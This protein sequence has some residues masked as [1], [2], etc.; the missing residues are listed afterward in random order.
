MK[1]ICIVL[2]LFCT[3]FNLLAYDDDDKLKLAV[4]EFED[5]SGKISKQTLSEATEY[6]RN[7][8][9]SSNTYIVIAKERQE[10]EMIKAMKKESYKACN[11]KNC[12]IPL[13]QAL[14]AD[15]IMRTTITYF[16]GVYTISSELIDLAKEASVIGAK[17]NYNGSEESMREA[18]DSIVEKI[19]STYQGIL[20]KDKRIREEEMKREAEERRREEMKREAEV[21]KQ[22]EM[23]REAE[24]RKRE[25]EIREEQEAREREREKRR[26][27][28]QQ[29]RAKAH[30]DLESG[31][32]IKKAGYGMLIVGA[33]S[34]AL[35][36]LCFLFA[37]DPDESVDVDAAESAGISFLV[38]GGAALLT[39]AILAPLGAVR[40]KKARIELDS[41]SIAP[42]NDG[43][44][45]SLG[46]SF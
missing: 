16:G 24:A 34:M 45:A 26:E 31:P 4:M 7:S 32:L 10:R 3:F 20:E 9:I 19:I 6:V 2:V 5:R 35:G 41:L 21:K 40:E 27:E 13:G 29:R 28:K 12:Q 17:K 22:E 14:A 37:T 39:G 42:T 15:T 33:S 23:R 46:F 18:L 30:D 44:Y 25:A 11:D 38:I 1:K 43:F 8:I 36:G